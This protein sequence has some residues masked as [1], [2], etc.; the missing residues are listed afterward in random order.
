MT[1]QMPRTATLKVLTRALA[2]DRWDTSDPVRWRPDGRSPVYVL[3]DRE[4]AAALDAEISRPPV[5]AFRSEIFR[6]THRHELWSLLSNKF[7]FNRSHLP[8]ID[9]YCKGDLASWHGVVAKHF[10]ICFER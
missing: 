3:L 10:G 7:S 4:Q 1:S 2:A 8:G 5:S 6:T 9:N